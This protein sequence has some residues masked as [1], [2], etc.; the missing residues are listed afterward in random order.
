MTVALFFPPH[1][2]GASSSYV[3]HPSSK[4]REGEVLQLRPCDVV[5]VFLGDAALAR[6]LR[7]TDIYLYEERELPMHEFLRVDFFDRSTGM[8]NCIFVERAAPAQT[9]ADEADNALRRTFACLFA[10]GEAVDSFIV[11]CRRSYTRRPRQLGEKQYRLLRSLHPP[12]EQPFT[13]EGL[14]VLCDIVS[15]K[16]PDYRSL[17]SQCFWYARSVLGIVAHIADAEH[18]VYSSPEHQSSRGNRIYRGVKAM[19]QARADHQRAELICDFDSAWKTFR[20]RLD[21]R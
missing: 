19:S 9:L 14:A 21:D 1:N 15:Q 11:P 16:Y 7:I 5:A 4:A 20:Q 3:R 13:L 8:C 10:G 18:H 12:S 2:I 17:T 6:R